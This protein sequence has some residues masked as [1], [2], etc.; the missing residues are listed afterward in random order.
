[1]RLLF[2]LFLAVSALACPAVDGGSN[3]EGEGEGEGEEVGPGADGDVCAFNADCG[4]GLRCG[5]EDGVCACEVGARGGGDNGVDTCLDENDCASAVCAVSAHGQR[6]PA[7]GWGRSVSR[8]SSLSI[9]RV[10]KIGK[11]INSWHSPNV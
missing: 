5:C 1:M 2:L 7:L 11:R 4:A 10:T 6:T 9:S 3:G 8:S